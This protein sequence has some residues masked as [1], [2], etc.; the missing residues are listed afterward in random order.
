VLAARQPD[1]YNRV[2]YRG[3]TRLR[4]NS[5]KI[6]LR[7]QAERLPDDHP[8]AR[9]ILAMAYCGRVHVREVFVDGDSHTRA[10]VCERAGCE[11][12]RYT[13]PDHFRELVLRS[14]YTWADNRR[15]A[16]VRA[17]LSDNRLSTAKDAKKAATKAL[18]KAKIPGWHAF[19]A[20]GRLYIVSSHQPALAA[21]ES[22]FPNSGHW[23]NPGRAASMVQ[24]AMT[25]R[26]DCLRARIS[27]R[28]IGVVTNP[29]IGTVRQRTTHGDHRGG[30]RVSPV[31]WPPR[32]AMRMAL[33]AEKALRDGERPFRRRSQIARYDVLV[34]GRV[35]AELRTENAPNLGHA[36]CYLHRYNEA[37]LMEAVRRRPPRAA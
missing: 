6:W 15:L 16:V 21:L 2:G 33:Q 9:N 10:L 27:A 25:V 36:L 19:I 37:R 7:Q 30:P 28:D 34:H 29:W 4:P 17:F 3:D 12:C 24:E 14:D 35:V 26:S 11:R 8:N 20:P 31:P 23:I 5:D 32:E 1:W 22:L 13:W 18:R